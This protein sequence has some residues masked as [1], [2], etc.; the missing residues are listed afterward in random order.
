[1]SIP[2]LYKTRLLRRMGGTSTMK[3]VTGRYRCGLS[4]LNW[5]FAS[6]RGKERKGK[7]DAVSA[8]PIKQRGP[9]VGDF[10]A[11]QKQRIVTWKFCLNK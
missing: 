3:K 2:Q 4:Q 6:R 5:E 7:R 8:V 1:M 11:R 10:L 9:R